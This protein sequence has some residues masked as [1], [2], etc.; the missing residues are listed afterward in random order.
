MVLIVPEMLEPVEPI[1]AMNYLMEL[2]PTHIMW[3]EEPI[4]PLKQIDEEVGLDFT[5]VDRFDYPIW[6]VYEEAKGG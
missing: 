3:F 5:F 6:P 4:D 2:D 1:P